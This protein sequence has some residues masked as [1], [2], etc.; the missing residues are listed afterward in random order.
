MKGAA[1]SGEK[2]HFADLERTAVMPLF[3]AEGTGHAAAAAGDDMHGRSAQKL[4]GRDGLFNADQGFLVA[5]AVEPDLN[6]IISENVGRDAAGGGFAG[7]E[8]IEQ[9]AIGGKRLRRRPHLLRYEVGI[10]I[11]ETQDARRLDADKR[12]VGGDYIRKKM[13]IADGKAACKLQTAL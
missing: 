5:M 12:S 8:L 2:D 10:L 4:Q 6:G 13:D 1:D 3:I 7:E 11:A 9:K